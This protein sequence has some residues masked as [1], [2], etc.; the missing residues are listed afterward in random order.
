MEPMLSRMGID[1]L[2]SWQAAAYLTQAEASAHRCK[3][4]PGLLRGVSCKPR[5]GS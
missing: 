1:A 2:A 4:T 5:G 3:G